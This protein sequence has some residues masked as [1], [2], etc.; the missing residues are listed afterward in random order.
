M[1]IINSTGTIS[2]NDRILALE[3]RVVHF[4]YTFV[5]S[6]KRAK[7]VARFALAR[8]IAEASTFHNKRSNRALWSWVAA[9][10]RTEAVA[11]I[12]RAGAREKVQ[13]KLRK[14]PT[15][16]LLHK[17]VPSAESIALAQ[18]G[19]N[20]LTAQVFDL[21]PFDHAT[22]F[23]IRAVDDSSFKEIGDHLGITAATARKRFERARALLRLNLKRD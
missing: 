8:A 4:A 11:E 3:P 5:K 6:L 10:T 2:L 20:D 12:R 23:Y 21:L 14:S 7:D 18:L 22:V 1:T 13:K 9:I 15:E 17:P 19:A 16:L